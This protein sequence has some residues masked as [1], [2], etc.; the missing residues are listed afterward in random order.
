MKVNCSAWHERRTKKNSE[1]PTEIEPS[2][3]WEEENIKL[4]LPVLLHSLRR[5]WNRTRRP[6]WKKFWRLPT[7]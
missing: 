3:V 5:L 7:G 2:T 6:L 4:S 1:S